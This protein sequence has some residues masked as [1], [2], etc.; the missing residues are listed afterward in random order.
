MERLRGF[1]R[2]DIRGLQAVSDLADVDATFPS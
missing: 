2:V 1:W